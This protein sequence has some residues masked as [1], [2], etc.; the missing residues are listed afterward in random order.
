MAKIISTSRIL[1]RNGTFYVKIPM[2][3]VKSKKLKHGDLVTVGLA[4]PGYLVI[5][6]SNEIKI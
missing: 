3:W 2:S 5:K 4:G 1:Y 6:S